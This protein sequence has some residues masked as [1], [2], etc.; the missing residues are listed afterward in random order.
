M[1][2]GSM[3][4][5]MQEKVMPAV[6]KFTNFH[7]VR[8]MQKGIVACTNATMIG[9]IFMLLLIPPFP[10]D[11]TGGL[12]DAWRNFSAANAALLNLG[13][14]LGTQFAG[15]YIIFGMVN[16]VCQEAKVPSVNNLVLSVLAFCFLHSSIVDG[17]LTIG[18]FGAQGMMAAIIVGY[19][20][21]LLNM[22]F[23][24]HGLRIKMP[25]SVPP[26]V[27]EQLEDMISSLMVMLVVVLVKLGFGAFGTTLGGFINKLF[28]PLFSGSDTLFTVLAYC[29]IVRILWFFGIHG[30]SVAGAV[31]NPILS[32]SAV[33]NTEAVVAGG[34]PT[35][36]FNSNFQQWT[37]QGILFIV[38]A[39]LLVAKSEQLKAVSRIALVP[40]LVNVGEPLT[41]GLPLVLNFDIFVPYIIVFALCGF[42]PYM[43]C[44][45]GLMRIPYVGV[46][47]TIPAIIKVF[48]MSMDWRAIVVYLVN[49][50]ICVAIMIPFIK[51]Y[52]NKLLAEEAAAQEQS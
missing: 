32:M 45:L 16:A 28:G 2:D 20:V 17:N 39:L 21:P 5:F 22:W 26:F 37:T 10:A 24:N 9:S 49:A 25:D 18:F 13:Y 36:I 12:V 7:F 8:C 30:N 47:F 33:A 52:D 44:K 19:F 34:E 23:K 43:A 15:F 1:A 50:V 31:I 42:T 27:S 35:I 6:N 41:F 4:T 14:T 3:T 11:M 46:P 51:R 48:L 40:A 29:I 38:I